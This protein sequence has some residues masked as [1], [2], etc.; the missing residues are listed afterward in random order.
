MKKI[1][2]LLLMSLFLV[3]TYGCNFEGEES[4]I[5][6]SY[7]VIDINPSIEIITD[8][9]GLIVDVNPLNDDA[10]ILLLDTNFKDLNL[11][12]TVNQILT[13]ALE[14]GYIEEELDNAILVTVATDSNVEAVENVIESE[15][16]KVINERKMKIEV[17]K[18]QFE[19]N[20][21]LI[22]QAEALG[23]SVGKL[24]L[25]TYAS[26]F[27][28]LSLE[29]AVQMPVRDLNN[30]LH[31]ARKEVKEFYREELK[32][33][34]FNLK[35]ELKV[36]YYQKVTELIYDTLSNLSDEELINLFDTI[37]V[38]TIYLNYLN[39]INNLLNDNHEE[40]ENTNQDKE[41]DEIITEL[42][43]QL[44]ELLNKFKKAHGR[45][46]KEFIESIKN[47]RSTLKDL[48]KEHKNQ[49]RKNNSFQKFKMFFAYRDIRHKYV[50]EFRNIGV[51][52]D[53]FEK[54]FTNQLEKEINNII[55]EL[56]EELE[57]VK[58]EF[59]NQGKLYR[60]Y[61]KEERNLLRDNN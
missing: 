29:E 22:S 18:S 40:I 50:I 21:E 13:L 2:L 54:Y 53:E 31:N 16:E 45:D 30:I 23:V 27:G 19:N 49:H 6:E 60:D 26:T 7:I 47:I 39:E 11:E 15:I 5:K 14:M 43:T 24:K 61:L 8:E 46:K 48:Y 33:Q 9:N 58:N 10:E 55:Y 57:A 35:D 20:E 4:S 37:E 12:E 56:Q 28:N 34:F 32:E 17:I 3:V 41:I 44:E 42:E 38:K 1:F 51:D 36:K 52:F 25:A 59:E